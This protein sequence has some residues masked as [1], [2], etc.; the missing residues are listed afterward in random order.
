MNKYL[1]NIIYVSRHKWF[2]FLE[3]CKLGI[4]W[5]GLVHDISKLRPSEF[6]PYADFFAVQQPRDKTGYYKPTDTGN[7][8]FD[9]AWFLHQK[10]NAHHWQYWIL[11]DCNPTAWVLQ[12]YGDGCEPTF[13]VG[14]QGQIRLAVHPED[15]APEWI[16]DAEMERSFKTARHIRDL[17]NQR[18]KV[19]PMPDQF[20]KEMLADWRGAGRAQRT[21]DTTA[22]YVANKDKMILHPETRAWVEFQLGIRRWWKK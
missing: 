6:F 10:R 15:Q 21:P 17:L 5:R 19:L 12:N 16:D 9:F 18:V 20:R 22:W 3:C 1:R 13:V 7:A 11:P 4:P 14:E 8:A 2:V